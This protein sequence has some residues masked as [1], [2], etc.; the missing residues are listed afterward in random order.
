[1]AQGIIDSIVSVDVP[2]SGLD[3]STQIIYLI[4]FS[5]GFRVKLS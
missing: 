1:M 3:E 2:Q 5:Y 4:V